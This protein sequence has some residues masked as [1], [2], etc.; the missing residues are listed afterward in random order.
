MFSLNLNVC[1]CQ[2]VQPF[3]TRN[4]EIPIVGTGE[5]SSGASC[6]CRGPRFCFQRYMIDHTACNSIQGFWH[7][8][9]GPQI[10]EH[11]WWHINSQRYNKIRVIVN[12]PLCVCSG[13]NF[14]GLVLSF[15]LY[16]GTE[17]QIQVIRLFNKSFYLL[18]HF[19]GPGSENFIEFSQCWLGT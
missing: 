17:D 11:I 10:P 9:L 14:M 7:C 12:K 4:L 6:S 19:T 15:H 1:G 18:R 2:E 3:R 8:L 16:R 5:M 13:D